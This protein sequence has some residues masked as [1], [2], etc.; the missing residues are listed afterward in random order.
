M[1]HNLLVTKLYIPPVRNNLVPRPRLVQLLNEAWQQGRKL[2]LVSASAGYGKTTLVSGWLGELQAKST[3]LSLDKSDNDPVRFLAYLIAALQ[4]IEGSIGENTRAILQASQPLPPEIVL[5]T[6]I[7]EITVVPTPFILVL[8]DYHVI[9]A[10]PIHQQLD[11]L[12]EHQPLQMHLVIITREDPPLPLARLRARGQMLEIRQNDLRFLA[13]ECA[14][15]LQ[16]VM[17]LHLSLDDITALENRT[18]GWIAGLQLA[19]LSMQGRDDLPDFVKDF[20][21]SSHYVLE[22]LIEEVFERQSVEA[23]DFLVKTSILDRLSGPLCDAVAD[24][25]DSTLLLDRLEHANLFI[26]PLDQSRTWY[27][28]HHLFA[29]LL[30]QRLHSSEARSENEFHRRASQWFASQGLFAE[31]IHHA[32]AASDWTQAAKLISDNSVMMLRRGELMT[33]LGWLKLLP[34]EVICQH[35]QLCRDYGWALTLTGQLD[36]ADSYLRRAEAAVQGD[37]ALL[38]E[39]LV[40]QAYNLRMRGDTLQAIERARRAQAFLPMEDHLSRGLAALTLGLAHWNYGSFGEAEQAFLEVDRAAQLSRN[41]Y[42][43]MTALSYL[44][45]IQAVYGR[46]HRAAELCRKVI[47]I[48][49]QSPT[50]APAHIELGALLYEWNDLDS[51]AHHLKAGIELSQRTGNWLIQSD[52]YRALSLVQLAAGESNVAHNTLENA[53]HL[54]RSHEVTPLVRMR[55]AACQVLLALAQKDLATARSWAEQVTE[56]ADASP[57]YPRLGLTPARLLLAQ[58][59]KLRA[60]EVLKAL[61]ESASQAGWGSGVVEV[62]VLQAI[63]ATT[64]ADALHFLQDALMRAQPEGFIRTFVDKGEPLKA[65][66]ERLKSQGGELKE[67]ILTILSAFGE[68]GRVATPQ[69]L[70]EPLSE[71]ELDVLR[72]VA[73]GMSNGEIAERL[74]VSVGTVKT[75]VHNLL[76]KLGVSSRTQAIARARE[77]ALL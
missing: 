40:A 39:I 48:G 33:L 24:R 51:A 55:N 1:S 63:A 34:D 11:F 6:L 14:D 30:R 9:E 22:Y 47:Q 7:N 31:A 21:G 28:Y 58:N 53:H 4:R 45:V 59:D 56:A 75:H 16:R 17:G 23:Q 13:E 36:A 70:V 52:G 57:F 54:A 5:T 26:I 49:E 44:G 71:R 50:V 37:E 25:L 32:L 62:R 46:L 69:R 67:Y 76:D 29:E 43:R 66:L 42:A 12:V 61:Y 3:W 38:G 74:V 41:H 73:E 60:G 64:P 68:R 77:L 15:F 27:R 35:P 20:S 10:L 18:E 8:D 19:A 65:L 72:L 2:T